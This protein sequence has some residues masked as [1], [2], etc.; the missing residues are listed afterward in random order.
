MLLFS[1]REINIA[2]E[3]DNT[4]NENYK[5]CTFLPPSGF[6][7]KENYKARTFLPPSGF[8]NEVNYKAHTD[9]LQSGFKNKVNYKTALSYCDLGLEKNKL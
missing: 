9:L 1:S 6:K 8:K 7:N 2:A 5:A 4:I 3:K